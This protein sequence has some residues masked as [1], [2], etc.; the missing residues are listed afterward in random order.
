MSRFGNIFGLQQMESTVGARIARAATA[1]LFLVIGIVCALVLWAFPRQDRLATERDA[2]LMKTSGTIGSTKVTLRRRRGGGSRWELEAW[3]RYEV[4]GRAYR[5]A[6]IQF[7]GGSLTFPTE[8]QVLAAR[9]SWA[10]GSPVTVWYDSAEPGN[11]ALDPAWKPVTG[12][13]PWAAGIGLLSLVATY[14]IARTTLREAQRFPIPPEEITRAL[15]H[16]RNI[17]MVLA[18]SAIILLAVHGAPI[19]FH[20][21]FVKPRLRMA[22]PLFFWELDVHNG[23]PTPVSKYRFRPENRQDWVEGRAW[24]FGRTGLTTM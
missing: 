12:L 15:R 7:H 9:A 6:R 24:R 18:G 23:P 11:S 3:Y 21:L 22:V 2:R 5:G 19:A 14:S 8:Q 17:C 10:D 16:V 13:V 1:L 20:D 4:G